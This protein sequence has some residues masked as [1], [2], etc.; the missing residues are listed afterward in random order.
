MALQ[1]YR[2]SNVPEYYLQNIPN[3]ENVLNVMPFSFSSPFAGPFVAGTTQQQIIQTLADSDFLCIS[4][5]SDNVSVVPIVLLRDNSTNWPLM[6]VAVPVVSIFGTAALP[7]FLPVPWFIKA[8]TTLEINMTPTAALAV[9]FT[10][11]FS[12]LR[13][14]RA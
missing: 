12:G 9:A 4:L 3:A 13:I 8:K 6:N 5:Q 2:P 1:T 14:F 11:T 7:Y 10:L